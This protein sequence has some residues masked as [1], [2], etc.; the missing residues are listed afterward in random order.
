MQD[1]KLIWRSFDDMT[2]EGLYA[3]LALRQ[4]VFIVEQASPYADADG[5]DQTAW[6]LLVLD[7]AERLV[8]TLRVLPAGDGGD[9]VIGRVVLHPGWR[10]QGLGGRM[11]TAAL[12]RI[13][14]EFPKRPVRLGAQ[15]V[16]RD[17]Y[18][19]FGFVEVSDIYD[20]AGIPHVDMRR[21]VKRDGTGASGGPDDDG[22]RRGA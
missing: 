6:H 12:E 5:R 3:L 14:R 11:M 8:G 16:Q 18:R 4:D 17:F 2:L 20:D 7:E 1:P 21:D 13:E 9:V 22:P 19:R 15:V 10:G